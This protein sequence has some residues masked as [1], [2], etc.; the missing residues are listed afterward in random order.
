MGELETKYPNFAPARFLEYE[1]DLALAREPR[2]LQKTALILQNEQGAAVKVEISAVLVPVSSK[3]ASVM[4]VDNDARVVYGELYFS[5]LNH[6]QRMDQFVDDVMRN[7]RSIYRDE[8]WNAL[9]KGSR[10]PGAASTLKEIK[11]IIRVK[12]QENIQEKVPG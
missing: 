4:F 10:F 9:Q 1:R 12:I 5:G 2:L 11:E 3:R 8:A 7:I 6:E